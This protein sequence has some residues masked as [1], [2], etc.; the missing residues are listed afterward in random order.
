MQHF[1]ELDCVFAIFHVIWRVRRESNPQPSVL[2]TLAL[3]IELRT[4]N[5]QWGWNRTTYLVHVMD[6]DIHRAG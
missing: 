5:G 2:E 3:P 4:Q 6:P 1:I